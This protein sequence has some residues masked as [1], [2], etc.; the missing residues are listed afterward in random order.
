MII[1]YLRVSTGKQ[2]LANQQN[3]I[4]KF[5]DSRNLHVDR[6]VTEIVSG[7]KSGRERKLG[8][9][10][11]RMKKGDTLI[12]TELS[13]LSRTLT[14]IMTIVGELLKKE[15]KLYSTKDRYSFDDT[16]NSKVL[17]FAFGLVAEIERNLIS[18]RTRE[19]LALRREQGIVLGRRKGSYT[20]LQQLID[21]RVKIVQMMNCGKS[22][23]AICREYDVARNTFDRFRK[24]YTY[25]IMHG[26]RPRYRVN[27]AGANR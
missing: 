14:D 5:T 23:A 3:E 1:A 18:M 25:I 20:K 9:L 7:K 4:S 24:Q 21:D 27:G 6:W 22:I 16:I 15:V 8:A 17:C 2:T 10:I 26:E 12:V 11:R 19:A 13:R